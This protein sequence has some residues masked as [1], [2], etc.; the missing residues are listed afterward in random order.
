LYQPNAQI[1][2]NK[3]K[4]YTR[5]LINT[6]FRFLTFSTCFEPH[7]VHLQED[8]F[9]RNFGGRTYI[10]NLKTRH[11]VVTGIHISRALKD[12]RPTTYIV[13]AH[14]GN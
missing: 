2:Q 12:L 4:K 10:R 5:F 13:L 1:T 9:I 7:G 6:L 8:I 14:S 11:S 3:P